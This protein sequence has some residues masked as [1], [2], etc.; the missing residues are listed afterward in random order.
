MP[1]VMNYCIFMAEE[2]FVASM[3]V[4]SPKSEEQGHVLTFTI[5]N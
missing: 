1:L 5:E 3:H 4:R 2:Y